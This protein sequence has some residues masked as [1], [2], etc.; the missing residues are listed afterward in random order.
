MGLRKNILEKE[1]NEFINDEIP[2]DDR[3]FEITASAE[4]KIKTEIVGI[5]SGTKKYDFYSYIDGSKVKDMQSVDDC[6]IYIGQERKPN[7]EILEN[8]SIYAEANRMYDP[9]TLLKA[10][11]D[12]DDWEL[13]EE[14][15]FAD[16]DRMSTVFSRALE[17]DRFER[18]S[19]LDLDKGTYLVDSL[20]HPD[21]DIVNSCRSIV[22]GFQEL[23]RIAGQRSSN[24]I[25]HSI[26]SDC[27]SG[28]ELFLHYAISTPYL[29]SL[30]VKKGK[31]H[32]SIH[33]R[34]NTL[35][36]SFRGLDLL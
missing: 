10:P 36:D 22:R 34:F 11:E 30:A 35:F 23:S 2:E 24:D 6:G 17:Q 27:P 32:S 4:L 18:G 25:Q 16:L 8:N 26:F 15:R 13:E 3:K 5:N 19:L 9:E 7:E 21:A 20:C 12:D 14:E 33:E 28:S 31:G 1:V 29:F